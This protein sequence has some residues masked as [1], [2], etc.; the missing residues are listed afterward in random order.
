MSYYHAFTI[1]FNF[2]M[3]L[4][5]VSILFSAII[6]WKNV[7][8]KKGKVRRRCNNR[9]YGLIAVVASIANGILLLVE[10]LAGAIQRIDNMFSIAKDT[11]FGYSSIIAFFGIIVV[12]FIVGVVCFYA[13][14]AAE[15]AHRR[16]Q[17]KQN[18]PAR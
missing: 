7:Y 15:K 4:I 2:W 17:L 16:N 9:L 8:F 13:A 10:S 6:G 3:V 12:T 5:P 18:H 11:S 1:G 14:I